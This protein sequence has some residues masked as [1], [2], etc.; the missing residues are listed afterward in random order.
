M[1][2][3]SIPSAVLMGAGATAL[4]DLWSIVRRRVFGIPSLNYAFVG[5]WFAHLFRGRFRHDSIA[6]T[7]PVPG[8][9]IVG[10][11]V[12]YLT[13]IVFAA[14]LLALVGPHWQQR[15]TLLPALSFGI[16]TLI[17]PFFVMQPGM[18]AGI[19]SSRTPRPWTARIQSLITHAIFGCGLYAGGWLLALSNLVPKSH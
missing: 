6:A 12:H 15:P 13:G 19:A 9:A 16:A 1:A 3:I 10:W 8:E 4:I 7:K 18:G 2:E 14:M 11:V 5:R 17:A